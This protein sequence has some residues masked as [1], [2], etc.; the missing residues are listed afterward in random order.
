[1]DLCQEIE[2]AKSCAATMAYNY[3]RAAT[4]GHASDEDFYRI[5]QLNAMIFTMER[6]VK[7]VVKIKKVPKLPCSVP[8]SA[9]KFENNELILDTHGHEECLEVEIPRC[10]SDEELCAMVETIHILCNNSN[11]NCN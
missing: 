7:K 9:L 6:N 3:A 11:C 1:M 2:N 5:L 10:L 4:F 8:L